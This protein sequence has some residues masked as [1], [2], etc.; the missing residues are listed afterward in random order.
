[1]TLGFNFQLLL[2]WEGSYIYSTFHCIHDHTVH[3]DRQYERSVR[4]TDFDI[5]DPNTLL[6]FA[7]AKYVKN[8]KK[9]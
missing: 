4:R 1:M 3:Q 5:E 7:N 6:Y 9:K 2:G 8:Q